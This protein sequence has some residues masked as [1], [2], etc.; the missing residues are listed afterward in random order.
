M[1]KLEVRDVT[2]EAVIARDQ[3]KARVDAY[4]DHCIGSF[5]GFKIPILG[6]IPI[7]GVNFGT[8]GY[9]ADFTV[10]D[11]IPALELVLARH[12]ENIAGLIVEPLVSISRTTLNG[13]SVVA[14]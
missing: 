10:E 12:A 6:D 2:K 11:M 3:D 13:E 14:K 8:L 1:K 5:H 4:V 7:L 9:L